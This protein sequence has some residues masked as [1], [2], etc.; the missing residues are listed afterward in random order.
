LAQLA[1]QQQ[2]Q[3]HSTVFWLTD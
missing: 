2:V 3:W 1:T